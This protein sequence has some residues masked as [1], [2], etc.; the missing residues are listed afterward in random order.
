[1]RILA[2]LTVTETDPLLKK[3]QAISPKL[4]SQCAAMVK[5]TVGV[6]VWKLPLV[7]LINKCLVTDIICIVF[8]KKNLIAIIF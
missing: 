6:L 2:T 3:L 8:K 7:V 1:M 5:N 4:Q